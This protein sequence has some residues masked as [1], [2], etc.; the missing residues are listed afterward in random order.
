MHCRSYALERKEGKHLL[1]KQTLK[2]RLTCLACRHLI[3]LAKKSQDRER[4]FSL[5]LFLRIVSLFLCLSRLAP[6]VTRVVI[7]VSRA[8]CST[9]QETRKQN[10]HGTPKFRHRASFTLAW[11]SGQSKI[12]SHLAPQEGVILRLRLPVPRLPPGGSLCTPIIMSFGATLHLGP[13]RLHVENWEC[14]ALKSSVR[15]Q[16][17]GVPCP[18]FSACK[19]GCSLRRE[20]LFTTY[21]GKP[22]DPRFRQM[23]RIIQDW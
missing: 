8:F 22:V 3:F 10:R 1:F 6:S 9:D 5:F 15:C 4:P 16:K 19:W 11:V 7:C 12:S 20:G 13:I 21:M 2:S 14:S 17:F 23:V 18:F